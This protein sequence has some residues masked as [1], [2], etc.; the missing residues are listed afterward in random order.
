[1]PSIAPLNPQQ[2][3]DLYGALDDF[4]GTGNNIITIFNASFFPVVIEK[5]LDDDLIGLGD[6]AATAY[7]TNFFCDVPRTIQNL[8]LFKTKVDVPAN[9]LTIV[10]HY[11]VNTTTGAITLTVAGVTFLGLE[12]L[13]ATYTIPSTVE[14][15]IGTIVGTLMTTPAQY[16]IDGR[17]GKITLTAAGV[18]ALGVSQLHAKY[19]TSIG[20][21]N[22]IDEDSAGVGASRVLVRI[23]K[24]EV[25][26]KDQ[27]LKG[28]HEAIETKAIV[29]VTGTIGLEP[30]RR[31]LSGQYV[32]PAEKITEAILIQ[33]VTYAYRGTPFTGFPLFPPGVFPPPANPS[34]PDLTAAGLSGGT[35]YDPAN[36]VDRLAVETAQYAS[37]IDGHADTN[38]VG[39]LARFLEP[40]TSTMLAA[41]A[42]QQTALTNQITA[43]TG[44]LV[45]NPVP[46]DHVSAG[47]I[48]DAMAASAAASAMFAANAAYVPTVTTAPHS[49]LANAQILS[50]TGARYLASTARST[51]ITATRMAAQMTPFL[52]FLWSRRSFW[53]TERARLGDGT[54]S[55]ID[56]CVKGD[57]RAGTILTQNAVRRQGIL[58]IIN[59]Q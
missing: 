30:E 32:T 23:K 40:A 14:L 28:I 34:I 42:A 44:F 51:F 59:A 56:Q 19:Y 47:N 43:I 49:G 27:D 54:L 39:W 38:P 48:A 41:I 15:H 21:I 31:Y 22:L 57:A 1:M 53:I 5:I 24:K 10:T 20:S 16:A 18:T 12:Q 45:N 58:D 6:N 36:E 26:P 13:H 2:L 33:N 9:Q 55:V 17:S 37:I 11:T 3:A 35:G 8:K 25:F 7:N 52:T 46:N 29:D 50:P 4:V